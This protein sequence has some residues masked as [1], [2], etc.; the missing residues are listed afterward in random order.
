[1]LGEVWT[2]ITDEFYPTNGYPQKSVKLLQLNE[3]IRKSRVQKKKNGQPR[4]LS[5][6]RNFRERHRHSQNSKSIQMWAIKDGC[7]GSLF[8]AKGLQGNLILT[9]AALFLNA[10]K[11]FPKL[12]RHTV[13]WLKLD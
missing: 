5:D 13:V 11:P 9:V 8:P 7:H 2:P 6:H 4:E 12:W 10:L 1:M 3:L